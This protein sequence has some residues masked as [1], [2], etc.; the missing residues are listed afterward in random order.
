[1]LGKEESI[2]VKNQGILADWSLIWINT[3]D[4]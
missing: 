1:M 4:D 2:P 3:K